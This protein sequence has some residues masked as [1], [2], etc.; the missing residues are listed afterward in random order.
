MHRSEPRKIA[1]LAATLGALGFGAGSAHAQQSLQLV[2]SPLAAALLLQ[3]GDASDIKTQGE[4]FLKAGRFDEA[5]GKFNQAIKLN[6]KYTA[7]YFQ[8]GNAYFALKKVPDALKDFAQVTVLA[9][10]NASGW[11]NKGIAEISLDNPDWKGAIASFTQVVE[12]PYRKPKPG[13]PDLFLEAYD[14]RAAAYINTDQFDKA[15]ADCNKALE[16]DPTRSLTHQNLALALS[17]VTPKQTDKAIAEYTAALQGASNDDKVLIYLSRAELYQDQKKYADVEADLTAALK[18]KPDNIDA[19]NLRAAARFQQEKYADATADYDMVLKLKPGG[20]IE[21]EAYRNRAAVALKTK[22]FDRAVADLSEYLKRNPTPK[23]PDVFKLRAVAYLNST[24]RNYTGALGDYRKYLAGKPTDAAAWK[25]LSVAAYGSAGDNPDKANPAIAEAVTAADKAI[26]LDPSQAEAYLIKAEGLSVQGKLA[27][28]VPVY[29]QFLGKRPDDPAG[30][31]G[32]GIAQYNQQNWADAVTDFEKYLA[33][34][35]DDADIKKYYAIALSKVP[36]GEEK[37]LTA[38]KSAIAANPNDPDGYTQIGVKYFEMKKYDD[39][40]ANFKKA[41]ELKPE[42]ALVASRNLANAYAAKAL[43]TKTDPDRQLAIDAYGKVLAVDAKDAGALA[44]RADLNL[45]AK[46]YDAAI[47]D[48]T[49]YLAV[50]PKDGKPETQKVLVAVY[51]NRAIAYS[52]KSPADVKSAV[53][54]YGE[55]IRLQPNDAVAYN[56]RALAL[57]SQKDYKGAVTDLDKYLTLK[58]NDPDALLNR[59]AAY[60]NL[61]IAA[62][63]TPTKG[64]AEFDKSVADYT[65]FLALPGKSSDAPALFSRGLAQYR[66]S[67]TKDKALLKSAIADFEAA[68]KVKATEADYFYY[69][70][71][72]SDN[73]GV[74]QEDIQE[75]M[76][77]KAIAA[78][79]KFTSLPGAPA[80]DVDNVKKRVAALKEAIGQ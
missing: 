1:L 8:R 75:E 80:A 4:G 70:G 50:A 59:A 13:D 18:V 7:A 79:E 69:L 34:K 64:G 47:G 32:R 33:K 43:E 51:T 22:Q 12:L 56:L 2:R 6:P 35:N 9:P 5:V 25:D 61:G 55:I 71:L 11:Y 40:I 60:Y 37:A 52:S 58:A 31:R 30:F 19:Y 76:F 21:S 3:D 28:A 78:Y 16:L 38:L 42:N 63:D 14:K 72:A 15:I 46:K 26:G 48:Y 66:K 39:A 45:A 24:P 74:A 41:T 49:N 67:G 20:E 65:A 44:A 10:K 57:L 53:A 68:T 62:K 77:Q 54:D 36:G 17:R 73:L 23:E 29:G 27:E